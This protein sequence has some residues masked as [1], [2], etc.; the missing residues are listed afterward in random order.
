MTRE[1][2][3]I[4]IPQ[5]ITQYAWT[6]GSSSIKEFTKKQCLWIHPSHGA[7]LDPEQHLRQD[8]AV[9]QA[10]E[11]LNHLLERLA[12]IDHDE[13]LP[14]KQQGGTSSR[15][16][17]KNQA[18]DRTVRL[19]KVIMLKSK[20]WRE[21]HDA[22][23]EVWTSIAG[24]VASGPL[25]DAG[26]TGAKVETTTAGE[27]HQIYL[28][29]PDVYDVDVSVKI[30][31][32][33]ISCHG[34]V[35]VGVKPDLYTAAGI[36]SQHPTHIDSLVFRPRDHPLGDEHVKRLKREFDEYEA[37][38]GI[39]SRADVTQ[40]LVDI[41]DDGETVVNSPEPIKLAPIIRL[42]SQTHLK[43]ILKDID[44]RP[45]KPLPIRFKPLIS[46]DLP[47]TSHIPRAM[48]VNLM[49]DRKKST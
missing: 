37:I 2:E 29:M 40:L 32:T 39:G 20:L 30:L 22:V 35:P 44:A 25:R 26:V 21:N 43:T 34:I 7:F 11:E 31:E 46:L 41:E 16:E 48:I 14:I 10:K 6:P 4:T 47:V 1:C 27:Q 24:S 8:A 19:L 15:G 33:L 17:V 23:D 13:N 36:T 38:F 28:Y 5:E 9:E 49:K 3:T 12:E 18:H 42:Q 45:I